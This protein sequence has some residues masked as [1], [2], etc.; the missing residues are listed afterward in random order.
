MAKA[1]YRIRNWS[2]Y[3]RSLVARGDVMLWFDEDVVNGCHDR[4]LAET[5]IG[6]FKAIFGP[7]LRS[8]RI[9]RQIAEARTKCRVLNRLTQLGMPISVRVS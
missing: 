5:G 1:R 8:R 7:G 4:S 3:N 2:E 9:E 6:R